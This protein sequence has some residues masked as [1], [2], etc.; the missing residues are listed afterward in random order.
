MIDSTAAAA[1]A[2]FRTLE[3]G[4]NSCYTDVAFFNVI[5]KPEKH[6]SPLFGLF[7]LWG[8]S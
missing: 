7:A 5:E 2:T 3:D 4:V 1:A 6:P 8:V